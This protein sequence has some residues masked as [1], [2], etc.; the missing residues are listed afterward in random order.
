MEWDRQTVKN[1]DTLVEP[2]TPTLQNRP[3]TY[4]AGW[5]AEGSENRM[6]FGGEINDIPTATGTTDQDVKVYARYIAKFIYLKRNNRYY[7]R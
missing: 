1:G 5:F 3:D 2:G 7:K 4:F 6:T